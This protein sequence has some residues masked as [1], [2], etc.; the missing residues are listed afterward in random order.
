[1][2]GFTLFECLIYIALFSILIVGTFTGLVA[3]SDSA[4]RNTTKAL[5]DDEGAYLLEKIQGEIVSD[6]I[7]SITISNSRLI[8]TDKVGSFPL[9]D[10]FVSV[11]TESIKEAG[12]KDSSQKSVTISLSLSAT[13]ST[14]QELSQD[15]SST[16]YVWP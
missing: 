16:L 14:G 12:N 3:F 10:N 5:L 4:A 8:Q 15:F 6:T 13:T 1:M 9:S 7:P 2:R 11:N